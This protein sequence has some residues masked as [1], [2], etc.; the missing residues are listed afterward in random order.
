MVLRGFVWCSRVH[1]RLVV[2]SPGDRRRVS[3]AKRE[4]A[5]SLRL[6]QEKSGCHD[7]GRNQTRRGA[8]WSISGKSGIFSK[9][10]VYKSWTLPTSRHREVV[11]FPKK[12][13]RAPVGPAGA[14]RTYLNGQHN[15]YEKA[16]SCRTARNS[17][18]CTSSFRPTSSKSTSGI[19]QHPRSS[20][21]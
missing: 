14:C 9:L 21:N 3:S 13:E 10:L 5:A 11:R 16:G 17:I 7:S 12:Y 18:D 15:K 1:G 6:Q 4:H 2:G 19:R 8:F 20:S